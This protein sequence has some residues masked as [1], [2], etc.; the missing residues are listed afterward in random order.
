[1][2]DKELSQ[3]EVTAIYGGGVPQDLSTVGPTANLKHWSALG[4]GDA[5]GAGNMINLAP[6]HY[7]PLTTCI[8]LNNDAQTEFVDFPDA[9]AYRFDKNLPFS[10]G[11][12]VKFTGT[13]F[14]RMFTKA[15]FGSSGWG[16]E[17]P[18]STTAKLFLTDGT[19]TFDHTATTSSLNDGNWHFLVATFDGTNAPSG[20][21]I[22]QDGSPLSGSDTGSGLAGSAA[23]TWTMR[24]GAMNG[25]A[26]DEFIGKICHSCVY[27]KQ[28]SAAEVSALY[29]GGLPQDLS[30]VGPTAN[31]QH[32]S[33]LGD[34]DAI[35]A[36]NVLDLSGGA[37][38]GFFANGESGD[39]VSDVPDGAGVGGTF[40]NGESEDFI[41]DVPSAVSS[42][43]GTF[44]NGDPGDFVSD[45]PNGYGDLTRGG[46]DTWWNA[47]ADTSA[48]YPSIEDETS[49]TFYLS[50]FTAPPAGYG[51]LPAWAAPLLSLNYTPPDG[52]SPFHYLMRGLNAVGNYV[53]WKVV[54]SPDLQAIYAPEI[55]PNL[56]TITIAG[57]WEE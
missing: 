23:S 16:L 25:I 27:N 6:P 24:V 43:V 52:E 15:L 44:L 47:S 10:I 9:V 38:H 19:T 4:D 2:Y 8:D 46:K 35:G 26:T 55:I 36:L 13:A 45:V 34:G 1:L 20:I 28:L 32:W 22:Y 37:N 11:V 14:Y 48:D 57:E 5:V 12:W 41:A 21:T 39:F 42:A 49:G 30:V 53:H 18:T 17:L 3:A 31:L 7:S 50:S 54:G 40:V 29:A 56:S 33:A 51:I